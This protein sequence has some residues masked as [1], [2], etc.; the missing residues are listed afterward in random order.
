VPEKQR[1]RRKPGNQH[2]KQHALTGSI[3]RPQDPEQPEGLTVPSDIAALK[4]IARI[5][6]TTFTRMANQTPTTLCS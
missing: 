1:K 5:F 3:K 4:K 2:A 6:K